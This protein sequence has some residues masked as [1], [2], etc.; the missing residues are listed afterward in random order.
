VILNQRVAPARFFY[1]KTSGRERALVR[2]VV[3]SN[4]TRGA[5]KN[6]T[7]RADITTGASNRARRLAVKKKKKKKKQKIHQITT[8]AVRTN[9]FLLFFFFLWIFFFF[10]LFFLLFLCQAAGALLQEL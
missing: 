6:M 5:K 9:A 2:G 7:G 8:P 3:P 1:K 4:L 10:Y